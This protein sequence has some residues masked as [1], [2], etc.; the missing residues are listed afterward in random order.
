MRGFYLQEIANECVR[1]ELPDFVGVW[2]FEVSDPPGVYFSIRDRDWVGKP[3]DLREPGLVGSAG[4]F[5]HRAGDVRMFGSG[6]WV[7]AARALGVAPDSACD[8]P[9]IVRQMLN[10]SASARR[11]PRPWWKFW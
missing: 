5:V 4:L 10:P 9:G 2:R 3:D 11:T 6:E 1:K 7:A 8:A